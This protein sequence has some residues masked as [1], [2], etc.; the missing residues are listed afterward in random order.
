MA[1]DYAADILD[2]LAR[3]VV[4]N[5]GVWV[6]KEVRPNASE[7]EHADAFPEPLLKGMSDMGLFGIKIPEQYGG[8]DLTFE[9]YAGVCMEL[10]RGWMSLAGIINTHVLV[11]YAINEYG[12]EAQK[13]EYLPKLVEPEMRCALSITEPDAGSDAQAIRTTAR[14]TSAPSPRAAARRS[15]SPRRPAPASPASSSAG[16]PAARRTSA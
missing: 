6:E 11:G 16:P 10:A 3:D 2:P 5:V 15:T 12:T 1:R 14:R 9:C 7:F 4:N 8:L 13:N